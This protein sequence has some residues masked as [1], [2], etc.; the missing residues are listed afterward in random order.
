MVTP[1]AV[2]LRVLNIVLDHD[3]SHIILAHKHVG[4]F[5]DII[6]KGADDADSRN[7]IQVLF[8]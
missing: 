2:G 1:V 6:H 3:H 4:H 7:I 5:I 8:H